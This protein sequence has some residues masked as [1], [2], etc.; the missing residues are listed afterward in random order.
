[1]GAER[2]EPQRE[3]QREPRRGQRRENLGPRAAA[4]NRR[5]LVAAATEVLGEQGLD[6]PL[7]SVARRAGVGQGSLY[8]HFPDRVS[9]AVAV[10]EDNVAALEEH[11]ASP[12]A[13][14]SSLVDLVTEQIVESVVLVDILTA[15]VRDPRLDAVTERVRA[16]VARSL[17]GARASGAVRRPVRTDDVVLAISM[18]AAVVAKAPVEDRRRTADAAW[19]LLR[20]GLRP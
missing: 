3:P 13:T 17:R 2:R 16:V 10:F 14:F 20:R 6:A 15:G 7:S 12:G 18:V 19:R 9:L 8:R 4:G 5:A 1:M 11:V